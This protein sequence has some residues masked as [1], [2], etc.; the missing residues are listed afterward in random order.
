MSFRNVTSLLKIILIILAVHFVITDFVTTNNLRPLPNSLHR[1]KDLVC[2]FGCTCR[3]FVL[4]WIL[5]PNLL[6]FE[7][8]YACPENVFNQLVSVVFKSNT[9]PQRNKAL[10]RL[11]LYPV[12]IKTL[13]L[14]FAVSSKHATW[15]RIRKDWSN[16]NKNVVYSLG[17]MSSFPLLP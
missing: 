4:S 11:K 5:Y 12:N 1:F 7:E 13:K 2:E 8:P 9:C 17:K 16:Q 10:N 15:G 14:G 3:K 6:I